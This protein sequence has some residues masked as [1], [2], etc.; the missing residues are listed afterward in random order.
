MWGI[1][2]LLQGVV[3]EM[4]K[5]TARFFCENC[6]SE[7]GRDDKVCGRCG[8][9]FASVRCPNCDMLG[10]PSQF[11]SGCPKC[12]YAMDLSSFG[13]TTTGGRKPKSKGR[14]KYTHH[15]DERLPAWLYI[16]TS[17]VLVGVVAGVFFYIGQ[18]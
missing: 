10:D 7:V 8:H 6:N 14:S 15:R 5:Q 17:V 12:G 9:F 13:I 4:K 16:L 2:L 3:V 18:K 11:K 1:L